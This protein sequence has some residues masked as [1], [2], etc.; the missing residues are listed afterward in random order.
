MRT[1]GKMKKI[2]HGNTVILTQYNVLI[3]IQ[4]NVKIIKIQLL[5]LNLISKT[6]CIEQRVLLHI[7]STAK[8][9]REKLKTQL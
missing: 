2:L 3:T 5:Y 6:K 7:E 9:I 4:K 8:P 1:V